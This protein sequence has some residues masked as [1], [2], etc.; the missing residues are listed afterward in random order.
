[1]HEEHAEHMKRTTILMATTHLQLRDAIV[2]AGDD[3][4]PEQGKVPL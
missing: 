4:L 3:I 1:M 2:T